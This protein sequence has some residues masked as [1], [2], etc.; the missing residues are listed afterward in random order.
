M[1]SPDID[2]EVFTQGT[3]QISSSFDVVAAL[4][5]HPQ[6]KKARFTNVLA[7]ADNGLYWQLRCKDAGTNWKV[8]VWLLAHDHAGPL[9]ASMV[10]PMRR[11]LDSTSRRRI[12]MLKEA[13]AW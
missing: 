1:V 7:S 12:L 3:P 13:R 2:L 9:S 11:A 8:D 6:V 5:E 4:A 10:E